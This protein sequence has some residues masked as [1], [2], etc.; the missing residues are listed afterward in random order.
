ML[1]AIKG[2]LELH[3]EGVRLGLAV[4]LANRLDF[5]AS[6]L[7]MMGL[8]FVPTLITALLYRNGL[9]FP[10]WSLHEALLVQGVFLTAK[11]I[12]YP[13]FGGLVWN[14]GE[15]VRE[16]SFELVLLQPR[17]PLQSC[18]ARAFDAEDLGKLAGGLA[19]SS[20]CLA[21]VGVP[22]ALQMAGFAV[23][24]ALSI[25]LF[26]AS[27]VAMGSL[28]IVWVGNFRVYEI[29]ET[30]ASLGQFP[31]TIL[32][33]NLRG[34]A[35]AGFPFAAFA[36]LPASSLLGRSVEGI[37]LAVA[38]VAILLFASLTLWNR[39]LRRLVGAGG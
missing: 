1:Q 19:L 4:R 38:S 23:F 5:A 39:L 32:P 12:A 14:T 35:V 20:W 8:E 37:W 27:I 36:V 21:H 34:L 16:G 10:G 17:H 3:L 13:L 26:L 18:M 25:A 31:S 9:A 24:F 22:S 7:V 2:H 29:F 15:M 11:G 6:L 30:M 28:L 33:K